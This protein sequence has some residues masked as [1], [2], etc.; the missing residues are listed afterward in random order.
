MTYTLSVGPWTGDPVQEITSFES[1][2][3]T[4]N[5]DAGDEL[6]WT[7]T[8]NCPGANLLAELETDCWLYDDDALVQRYR[9]LAI[10]ASWV[11]NG[12]SVLNVKAV[13]YKKLVGYRLL[14]ADLKF[15]ATDQADIVWGIIQATQATTNGD[16]GIVVG[17]LDGD[18]INR[19]RSYVAGESLGTILA[20]L[21]E[22]INGPY[23]TINGDLELIV[24]PDDD[25]VTLAT[26]I[27]L[28]VTARNLTRQSGAAAFANAVYVD[29]DG[30]ST[31][32]VIAES[33]TIATDPRG[34][35]ESA[36]GFPSVTEQATLQERADGAVISAQSPIA[37][38]AV[39][40][41]PERFQSD[42][43]LQ[44]GVFVAVDWP[45]TEFRPVGAT[46]G[47]VGQVMTVGLSISPDG[48]LKVSAQIIETGFVT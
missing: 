33:A 9:V 21:S 5:L 41:E 27:Q 12:R 43:P 15:A 23:W 28:G 38:W 8:C 10:E 17:S 30:D 31:V 37:Q 18:G 11:V 40:V 45:A 4:F 32:P 39:D 46:D 20:N 36:L 34:R 16:F 19:D 44:P 29:G 26:P 2:S 35:W 25:F 6:S 24:K 42:L 47:V 3:A 7:M 13:S 22:V 14:N 48:D 1:I